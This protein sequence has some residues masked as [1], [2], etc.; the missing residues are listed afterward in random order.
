MGSHRE[1]YDYFAN[2]DV[3]ESVYNHC[4]RAIKYG[5]SR[6]N[7]G[8]GLLDI[9]DGDWNDGF[10]S[11]RGQSVWLTFFM[12][13]ILKRFIKIAKIQKD[14]ETAK[15]FMKER[16]LLKHALIDNAWDGEYF[17]RAYFANGA[18]LGSKKNDECSIDLI[19]QAWATIA[20]KEYKDCQNEITSSLNSVEKYLVDRNNML[21][22]LLYPPI[23]N[24]T[25]DPGYIK[26]YIPG[27][28]ENGGQYTHAAIWLPKAY[29]EIGEME[30]GLDILKLINPINHGDTKEKIDT[31]KVEPYV[32]TADVYSNREHKGR[33]GWSWYTGSSGWMYKVIED[34]LTGEDTS[35]NY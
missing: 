22:R 28:R 24:M 1:L 20:L 34:Y 33:G 16:H 4:L 17:V 10:S 13:D 14:D 19:S 26:A 21:V 5:L 31:Y 30:K 8:N 23:D 9:G 7:A 27:I 3:E 32:V 12:M 25:N 29:F 11:I 18:V 6:K 35:K 15:L 2:I